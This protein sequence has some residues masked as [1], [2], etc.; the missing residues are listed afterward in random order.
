MLILHDMIRI[1]TT[2]LP[3]DRYWTPFKRNFFKPTHRGTNRQTWE[4]C[5]YKKLTSTLNDSNFSNKFFELE[6]PLQSQSCLMLWHV[7]DIWQVTCDMW[8]VTYVSMDTSLLSVK[9]VIEGGMSW[10]TGPQIARSHVN[11]KLIKFRNFGMTS[12][13]SFAGT[14]LFA[15]R[16]SSLS[17]FLICFFS[18]YLEY[19]HTK[20]S[21]KSKNTAMNAQVHK[22]TV[23]HVV[24]CSV[25]GLSGSNPV[26]LVRSSSMM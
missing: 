15:R 16:F 13:K 6:L 10:T 17:L 25:G 9:F 19:A 12:F 20:I 26:S 1:M 7:S 11:L 24:M 5:S 22:R 14:I 18:K 3:D 23:S 21:G 8:H 2:Y 4:N